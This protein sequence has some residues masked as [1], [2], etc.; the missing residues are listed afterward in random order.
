MFDQSS[1]RIPRV[2]A[3]VRRQRLL[4]V[5]NPEAGLWNGRRLDRVLTHLAEARASLTV[6]GT[7]GVGEATRIARAATSDSFDAVVVAGGDGTVNEVVNGLADRDLPIAV[8][9]FGTANVL[10]LELALPDDPAAIARLV[11]EGTPRSIHLGRVDDR[12]FVMMAGIGFDAH[13]VAAVDRRIKRHTGKLAY[14]LTLLASFRRF[15]YPRYRVE[16][17][18]RVHGAASLVVANGHFYGGRFTCAPAASLFAPELFACL[19]LRPGAP[20]FVSYALALAAGTLA[21]RAD[22][23]VVPAQRIVVTADRSDEPVQCDGD[24]VGHLPVTIE[25]AAARIQVLMPPPPPGSVAG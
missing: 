11:L 22:V 20:A 6:R 5:H 16:I 19:L 14:W 10:A 1:R 13:V 4:V 18:G 12:L 23:V 3:A 21:R 24:I 7:T 8:L 2:D 9:P 25:A 15:P 17:D